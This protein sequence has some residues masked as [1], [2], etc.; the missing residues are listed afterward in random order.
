MCHS[1]RQF[2]IRIL[3]TA[4]CLA[5]ACGG[6]GGDVQAPPTPVATVIVQ[7][8]ESTLAAGQAVQLAATARDAQGNP[9][10]DQT[11]TWATANPSI[12]TVSEAGLVTGVGAGQTEI[13][14]MSDTTHG[15][16]MITVTADTTLP[17]PPP[18]GSGV[19]GLQEIVSG[20]DIPV[21][22]TSPPNDD[23]LFIV[24]K[25]GTIRVVEAGAMLPTPFLDIH[26]R[27]SGETEQGLLGLAFAPDYATTGRFYVYYTD[28]QGDTRVSSFLVS[29]DRN[30]ADAS[31]EAVV[32]T[33][34]QPGVSHKGG[35]LAF[36]PDGMLYISLGD[37][38]SHDGMDHG[39]GQSLDDLLGAILR[40]D[41]SSGTGY[42]V[43]PDNPFVGTP[44]ARPEI[45]SYG[46]RNPWRYSFDRA[47]GDV[48]IADVG[49]SRWEEVN[50]ARA[51]EGGGRGLNYGWS[52]MQGDVCE[53]PGCDTTGLTLPTFE[54]G[55]D[56][57]CA[58]VGGYVYRGSALPALAGQYIF[59]DFCEG[60]VRSFPADGDPGQPT[61]WPALSPGRGITAFG[62]DAAGELYVITEAGS[63]LKMVPR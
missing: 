46:L 9:L 21:F 49:E 7:A 30:H 50:R 42:V 44:G 19:P 61:D 52:V 15:G 51:A 38:G 63:V 54:Y 18:T 5:I 33:Q 31:T 53:Q 16:L 11:F 47:T 55:H 14:A 24:E 28:V 35:D 37:G 58:I 34:S 29:S 23:R 13:T 43:P 41:V 60:W 1:I 20:L 27:V 45:W 6:D 39:H 17:P 56:Q 25:V 8:P 12:A 48:Y 32:L 26:D 4:A 36:G 2:G 59:G 3:P 10:A 57:G 62:Q 40:I 22:L